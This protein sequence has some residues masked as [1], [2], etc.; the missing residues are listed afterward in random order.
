MNFHKKSQLKPVLDRPKL[1]FS[2]QR[3]GVPMCVCSTRALAPAIRQM[4]GQAY[5][6]RASHQRCRFCHQDIPVGIRM[7]VEPS[8]SI[9]QSHM[10]SLDFP[11]IVSNGQYIF[12]A[13]RS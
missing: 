1:A 3:F 4:T 5:R 13:C 12:A 9:T 8:H 11:P 7:S 10:G 2:F 6:D